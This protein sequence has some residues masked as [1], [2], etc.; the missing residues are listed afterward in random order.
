MICSVNVNS[1]KYIAFN[2]LLLVLV[3]IIYVRKAWLITII[4]AFVTC[5]FF[6][7]A[8]NSALKYSVKTNDIVEWGTNKK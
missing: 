7:V 3:V 4:N 8:V 5:Y 6:V 1:N 2:L